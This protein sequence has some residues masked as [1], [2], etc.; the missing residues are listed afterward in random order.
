[1]DI[2]AEF[3]PF[4]ER[5]TTALVQATKTTSQLLA[6]DIAFQRSINPS[7]S[8][9][10]DEQ[11]SRFLTLTNSILR[12]AT[13]SS[14][15]NVAT[16][17]DEE[18][19]DENWRAV[20]DV[21]DE[22]LEKA[23]ACLDE[24]TGVIK[25]LTPSQD[26]RGQ[27]FSKRASRSQFPSVYDFSSAKLPKPQ[28][29]FNN[30]PNNHDSSPFRPILRQKPHA[31][32]S[33][34]LSPDPAAGIGTE[35]SEHPYAHE[36]RNCRYPPSVYYKSEPQMYQPFESTSAT[37]VNTMEGVQAMLKEL[38]CAK[39]I[40]IDLEHH[41]THSYYGLVCLMQISTRDK[42]WIVDTLLPW[43]EE[44]QILNEV[45]ANPQIVK[46]L[47]GSSMDV[48]WLQRDLGL[49][50]VG[51][52]DTY[53]AAAAL[54]YPKKSLKF[55]LDK[56]VNFQAE[57][58]YQIADWRVRPLLPGM[59]DYARSDTHYLLYIYDH[60]RNELIERST[61]GENLIDYVQ[62]N[63]KEEAL[64]RYER[65]VYD[66]ETGQGAGGCEIDRECGPDHLSLSSESTT[67]AHSEL[68]N[69]S[70]YAPLATFDALAL[71]LPLPSVP[72][73]V[74][75]EPIKVEAGN[76][77]MAAASGEGAASDSRN[78]PLTDQIFTVKQFGA[79][80]KRK[81]AAE[82]DATPVPSPQPNPPRLEVSSSMSSKKRKSAS[83]EDTVPFDYASADSVLR[84][85]PA[86]EVQSTSR[87]P[88]FN[89]Y[90][91][92][93]DAPQALRKAKKDMGGG[94]SFTFQ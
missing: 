83:N 18:T 8:S 86:D 92:A 5:L 77:I 57:K 80:P 2:S 24:F 50:L 78:P 39:E 89:P 85:R 48:I 68:I 71:S 34:P 56:F 88:Q 75:D 46:V 60:L 44:L 21:I 79:P 13:S 61:P 74:S 84:G 76:G 10:L 87:K 38:K 41:D 15:L 6:E 32:V 70:E 1:M 42:D 67:L 19:V 65:P 28:L 54:H 64:Q 26:E 20:V 9:S 30:R 4:Q 33:L 29:S 93:L 91:K 51:L 3:T 81:P 37:F 90:T 27:D 25:K 35:P 69:A 11:S 7:L 36:I 47:H 12:F 53:H 43:R 17:E 59:F 73:N 58:K 63:S 23:D 55:L 82:S 52:F 31:I 49:Y 22:L 40:G 66:T 94:K 72:I 16:L 14:D 62:E 45:F